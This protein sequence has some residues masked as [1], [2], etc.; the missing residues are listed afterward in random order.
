MEKPNI[1]ATVSTEILTLVAPFRAENDVRYYL[2]SIHVRP[3]PGGGTFVEASDG[4]VLMVAHD[5]SGHAEQPVCISIQPG[6]LAIAR[7]AK[8]LQLH[9]TGDAQ[10][11]DEEGMAIWKSPTSRIVS[12]HSYP[13]FAK[14]LPPAEDLQEG[15]SGCYNPRLL[16]RAIIGSRRP[17]RV[18]RYNRIQFF[19]SKTNADHP[20][21][22][23]VDGKHFGAV[24]PMRPLEHNALS[25]FA[26]HRNL[27]APK[28]TGENPA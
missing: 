2:N 6:D 10:M 15:I 3:R 14:A 24:M 25:L 7:R 27:L 22:F 8:C 17:E 4:H 9:A 13:N 16:S 1:I 11:V 21:V 12:A 18:S 19:R 5:E 26:E 23:V 20:L 28:V